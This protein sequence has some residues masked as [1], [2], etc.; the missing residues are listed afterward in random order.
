MCH[1]MP[2]VEEFDQWL[3]ILLWLRLETQRQTNEGK[4]AEM[5]N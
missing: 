1:I 2:T 4:G 3:G 5:S